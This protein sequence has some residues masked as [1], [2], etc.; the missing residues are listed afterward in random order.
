MQANPMYEMLLEKRV[1]IPACKLADIINRS[2][3]VPD[4][5]DHNGIV[6]LSQG[7]DLGIILTWSELIDGSDT[8]KIDSP[9]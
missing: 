9:E 1:H 7:D 6:D 5:V 3:L 2:G 4:Y 8:L